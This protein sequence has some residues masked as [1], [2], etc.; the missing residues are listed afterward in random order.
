MSDTSDVKFDNGGLF[1]SRGRGRHIT[2]VID[3]YELIFVRSGVLSI[4]ENGHD[5]E[6]SKGQY[7]ILY[8]VRTHGG[9]RDYPANLSFFWGHFYCEPSAL[10]HLPQYGTLARPNWMSEY[11]SLLLNAQREPN[12]HHACNLLMQLLLNEVAQSPSASGQTAA[13]YLAEEARRLLVL[14]YTDDLSTASIAKQLRCNPDY[15]GHLFHTTFGTTIIDEL[16]RIR[17]S[18]AAEL[19]RTSAAS[20]KEIAWHCGYND[21]AY[22]RRRFQ[23]IYSLSPAQYRAVH[24]RHYVNSE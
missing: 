16:N 15:L 13:K 3:S 4:Q 2:R 1:I 23:R 11:Y 19:L 18:H 5:F 21:G 24:T 17:C 8:P 6:V 20:A 12:N 7:I 14:N 22:F 10:A 9:T